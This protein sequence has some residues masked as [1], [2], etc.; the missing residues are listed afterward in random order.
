MF[1]QFLWSQN[2][3]G[4]DNV[5]P[6]LEDKLEASFPF[7]IAPATQVDILQGNFLQTI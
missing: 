2:G 5:T 1:L 3:H 7:F 6:R 4:K